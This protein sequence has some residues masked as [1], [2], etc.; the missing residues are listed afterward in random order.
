MRASKAIGILL[1]AALLSCVACTSDALYVRN[2]TL[3]EA[4]WDKEDTL[5]FDVAVEDTD[6]VAQVSLHL[7]TSTEYP[8]KS[9]KVMVEERTTGGNFRKY[10]VWFATASDDGSR[11]GRRMTYSDLEK[12]LGSRHLKKDDTLHVKVYH[13]MRRLVLPGVV[14]VGVRAG[15]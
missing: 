3:G 9:L 1:G 15:E 7:R 5:R 8:Y 12:P 2:E 6:C 10:P 13:K 4:R 14:S 11:N